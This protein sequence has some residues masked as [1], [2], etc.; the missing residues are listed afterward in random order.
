VN[1]CHTVEAPSPTRD[2]VLAALHDGWQRSAAVFR[3]MFELP[4][5]FGEP[6]LRESDSIAVQVGSVAVAMEFAGSSRGLGVLSV[7]RATAR[8]LVAAMLSCSETDDRVTPL[9][10]P[11]VLELGNVVINSIVGDLG[12]LLGEQYRFKVPD[13]LRPE[14]LRAYESTATHVG[15][16]KGWTMIADQPPAALVVGVVLAEA[17]DGA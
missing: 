6:L 5:S 12:D 11:T 17:G 10:A 2:A 3:E 7:S 1:A 4:V 13:T 14:T 15:L 9:L 16:L 8:T